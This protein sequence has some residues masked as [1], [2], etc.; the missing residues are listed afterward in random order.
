MTPSR[1]SARF[2]PGISGIF[3]IIDRVASLPLTQY[4][5]R[6]GAINFAI[7]KLM[8]EKMIHNKT[9]HG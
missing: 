2:N 8:R 7:A 1:K 4:N 3:S 9:H 5:F 6:R